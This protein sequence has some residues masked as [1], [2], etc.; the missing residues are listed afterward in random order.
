MS[1]RMINIDD[2]KKIHGFYS[3]AEHIFSRHSG[4]LYGTPELLVEASSAGF[5]PFSPFFAYVNGIS[6][7]NAY[8]GNKI[9]NGKRINSIYHSDRQI[10]DFAK[11][12][13]AENIEELQ[14]LYSQLWD[15]YIKEHPEYQ[16]ILKNVTAISD[17]FGHIN[18]TCQATELWRIRSNLLN[19]PMSTPV[20]RIKKQTPLTDERQ[21]SLF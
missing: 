7:E 13:K 3:N 12:K 18:G 1:D 16:N 4:V 8:Q 6:I 17:C 5:K 19:I 15:Q 14:S 20:I 11:G 9:I 21:N 2:L 10:F